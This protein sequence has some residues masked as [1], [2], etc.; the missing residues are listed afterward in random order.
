MPLRLTAALLL[1]LGTPAS[2][3]TISTLPGTTGCLEGAPRCER[4][5]NE[6]GGDQG[7]RNEHTHVGHEG[8]PRHAGGAGMGG[9]HGGGGGG[10]SGDGHGGH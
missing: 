4:S 1:A 7:G 8:G 10:G 9:G 2:A 3:A 5:P 6:G